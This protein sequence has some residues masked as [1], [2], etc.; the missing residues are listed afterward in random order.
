MLVV[1]SLSQLIMSN[2]I[3]NIHSICPLS[4]RIW[5]YD[6]AIIYEDKNGVKRVAKKGKNINELYSYLESR[7][8]DYIPKIEYYNNDFYVY[9]YINDINT[10]DEQKAL[11]LIN[12]YAL[13]HNKTLYYKDISIDEVK[14]LYDYI[15]NRI[16]TSSTYYENI[17]ERAEN[18]I[19]MSPS[20]YLLARN[21]SSI[22][23]CLN[24]CKVRLDKWYELMKE[25]LKKRVVLLH[26][27]PSIS[28]VIR[29][30]D[31]KY[32]ISWNKSYRDNATYDLIKFYKKYYDKY[33]F[34][35]LYNIYLKKFPLLE[36]ERLLLFILLF[37]PDVTT[38]NK[39]EIINTLNIYNLFNYLYQTDNL[40]MKNEAKDAK[41]QNNEINKQKENMKS[42]T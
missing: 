8:F 42:N 7:G 41:K 21:Y 20:I 12:L 33:D 35:E 15:N 1:K 16:N 3:Y 40:F 4:K 30:N 37:L 29:N 14:E 34:N 38:Y 2:K 23:S 39:S 13:L 25:K 24:F 17:I 9:K 31:N 28:H 19:F 10:P 18:S 22:I 11:D 6:K 26:N 27:N 36:E 5:L 32:L